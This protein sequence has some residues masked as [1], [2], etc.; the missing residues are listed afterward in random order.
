MNWGA[1]RN[2]QVSSTAYLSPVFSFALN[3]ALTDRN[4]RKAGNNITSMLATCAELA[5]LVRACVFVRVAA[6]RLLSAVSN[7]GLY[8]EITWWS[9]GCVRGY[10]VLLKYAVPPKDKVILIIII[11]LIQM[12]HVLHLPHTSS[13]EP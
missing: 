5:R 13:E 9:Y 10:T 11:G 12:F 8:F 4:K 2:L 3:L 6:V 7:Q 1:V